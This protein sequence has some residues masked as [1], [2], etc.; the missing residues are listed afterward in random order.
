MNEAFEYIK[1]SLI[2]EASPAEEVLVIDGV[3][4]IRVEGELLGVKIEPIKLA[5]NKPKVKVPQKASKKRTTKKSS[6]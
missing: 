1:N 4:C 5:I 3:I 2:S 6:P